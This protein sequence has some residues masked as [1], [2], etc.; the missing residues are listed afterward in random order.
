M[1]SF[2]FGYA[3]PTETDRLEAA[4]AHVFTDMRERP[5]PLARGA[6]P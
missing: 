5:T 2:R 4:G 6:P 3:P 1:T